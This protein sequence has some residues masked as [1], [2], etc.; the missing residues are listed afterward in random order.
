[1][2]LNGNRM[3]STDNMRRRFLEKEIGVRL[4]HHK[5]LQPELQKLM[6]KLD[7]AM[8]DFFCVLTDPSS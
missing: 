8:H 3:D 6:Q 7:L 5:F 4:V 1:M 2:F